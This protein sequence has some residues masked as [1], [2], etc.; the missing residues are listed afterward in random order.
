VAGTVN[1]GGGGGA[2]AAGGSGKV[3]VRY[4]TADATG[5]T[6]TRTGTT[7]TGTDG[8]YTWIS[9]TATGTLVVA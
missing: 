1:T 7:T 2:A 4:L 9:W 5:L 3:I 8:S 6:I